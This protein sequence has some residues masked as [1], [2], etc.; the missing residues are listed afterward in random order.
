MPDGPTEGARFFSE[1]PSQPARRVDVG[2]G[3]GEQSSERRSFLVR[4]RRGGGGFFRA[5]PTYESRKSDD[6]EMG[7]ISQEKGS[8]ITQGAGVC[9]SPSRDRD[10][11]LDGPKKP[12]AQS[13][14]LGL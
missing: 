1:E 14:P 8:S 10:D 5:R 13:V 12:E 11:R 3:G 7:Q 6:A 2:G 4:S 9:S